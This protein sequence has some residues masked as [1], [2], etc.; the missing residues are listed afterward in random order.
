MDWPNPSRHHGA[1]PRGAMIGRA[2]GRNAQADLH[3]RQVR[4]RLLRCFQFRLGAA[5]EPSANTSLELFKQFWRVL[6]RAASHRS[7]GTGPVVAL[8]YFSAFL[9]VNHGPHG[10]RPRGGPREAGGRV[11]HGLTEY[12]LRIDFRNEQESGEGHRLI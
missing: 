5:W 2:A 7:T 10:D 12:L 4:V 11:P 3:L 6:G 8:L 1:R 9:A